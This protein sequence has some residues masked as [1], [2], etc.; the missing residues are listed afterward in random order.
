LTRHRLYIIEGII[1]I[2]I[3]I[4]CFWLIPKDYQTAYFLN[5]EDRIIMRRRAELTESYNGGQGHYTRKD[6]MLAVT[7]VKTWLHGCIQLAVMTVVYGFGV[8]LPIII[9]TGFEYS[10]K[11]A[12]YLAIP[13][14]DSLYRE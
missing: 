13:G 10:T 9:K 2:F 4:L 11:Q 14:R 5:A 7:D 8:F 6:F 1:T 3:G 12:Q